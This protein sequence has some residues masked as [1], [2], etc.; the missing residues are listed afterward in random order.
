MLE[1]T[2]KQYLDLYN[3]APA[4]YITSDPYGK[5]LMAT[6]TILKILG[7][8]RTE[9]LDYRLSQFCFDKDAF[10]LHSRALI[11]NG[12][13]YRSDIKM[14]KT[15]GGRPLYVSVESMLIK[16]PGY[17]DDNMIR[18]VVTDV[19]EQ[20]QTEQ[21]LLIASYTAQE[22]NRIKDEF[23]ANMSHEIRTP[24]NAIIGF[25]NNLF[26]E[27]SDPEKL[28]KLE[29]IKTSGEELGVLLND[30]LDFSRIEAGK[31]E[32]EKSSF[33]LKKTLNYIY[34][35]YKKKAEEKKLDFLINIDSQVPD[36]VLGDKH[37]ISQILKNIID[38]AIKYTNAYQW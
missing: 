16:N 26:D 33:D 19:S 4:G 36:M 18:S 29:I 34:S 3:N 15:V 31:V 17:E 25:A 8:T 1:E 30:I 2:K 27:E 22:A 10:Y 5:I 9:L 35:I 23:L 32:I 14:T 21:Q 6:D 38:N 37:G 12:S 28:E 20:K 7:T 24:L 11:K 13:S